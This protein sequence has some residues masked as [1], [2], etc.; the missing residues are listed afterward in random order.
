VNRCG[1]WRCFY[2][3]WGLCAKS[4]WLWISR[5]AWYRVPIQFLGVANNRSICWV[6]T[7][8]TRSTWTCILLALVESW[9]IVAFQVNATRVGRRWRARVKHVR[10][11]ATSTIPPVSSAALVVSACFLLVKYS[12]YP[13][14]EWKLFWGRNLSS[15][16][17]LLKALNLSPPLYFFHNLW[18]YV[19]WMVM[20]LTTL[21]FN[22]VP[23]LKR[24]WRGRYTFHNYRIYFFFPL[25]TCSCSGIFSNS[26]SC[27]VI[28]VEWYFQSVNDDCVYKCVKHSHLFMRSTTF[29]NNISVVLQAGGEPKFCIYS[30][31]H[32]FTL[33]WLHE[34]M[35]IYR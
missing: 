31:V 16:G 30:T 28:V 13:S 12:T 32:W 19:L 21:R 4:S 25:C 34:R 35:G 17:N 1:V 2:G 11:W 20:T 3:S 18:I 24:Q 27:R 9:H 29:L 6:L 23:E 14:C 15:H 33:Y 8:V 22:S 7:Q 26:L 5:C 10:R